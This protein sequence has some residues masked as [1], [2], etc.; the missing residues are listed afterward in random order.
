[1]FPVFEYNAEDLV[2]SEAPDGFNAITSHSEYACHAGP[3]FERIYTDEKGN[4][5]WERG[6]R[7]LPKHTN[8]GAMAH[9]GLLMTFA[10]VLLATAVFKRLPP[11]FVTVKM[12][13]EF[14]G[15]APV[16][17]W[18]TGKA[19]MV[20]RTG[21]LAF[22]EGQLMIDSKIIF[23]VSGIFKHRAGKEYG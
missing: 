18:V 2:A 13:S 8:A 23:T 3:I 15:R 14:L 17:A 1:M 9:G 22:L 16:G 19:W 6:F 7:V 10:D 21:S 12:T 5:Q 4:E 20:K 11:P